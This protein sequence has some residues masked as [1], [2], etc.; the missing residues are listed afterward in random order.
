MEANQIFSRILHEIES[1]SLNYM[2][3]RRTPFS[4]SVSLKSSFVR[5]FIDEVGKSE[6]KP[7]QINTK[8][9]HLN[10]L[11]TKNVKP[12]NREIEL[13]CLKMS[14]RNRKR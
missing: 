2:N 4:A 1:S 5:H 10:M 9:M 6:I 3:T 12:V 11:E 7:D 8:E 14:L 13:E